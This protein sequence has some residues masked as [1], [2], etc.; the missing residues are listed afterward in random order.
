MELDYLLNYNSNKGFDYQIDD[1][2]IITLRK[3][4]NIISFKRY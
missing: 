4:V 1:N 3:K 2:D